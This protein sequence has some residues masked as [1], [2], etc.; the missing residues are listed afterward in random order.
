MS[1]EKCMAFCKEYDCS[2]STDHDCFARIMDAERQRWRCSNV[3]GRRQWFNWL[4][5]QPAFYFWKQHQRRTLVRNSRRTCRRAYAFPGDRFWKESGECLSVFGFHGG[6]LF[7]C[8]F[9]I[10]IFAEYSAAALI[11]DLAPFICCCL[12]QL[13]L[14]HRTDLC[15]EPGRESL[16]ER[17]GISSLCYVWLL[18]SHCTVTRLDNPSILCAS[19]ILGSRCPAR[20]VNRRRYVESNS[21]FMGHDVVFLST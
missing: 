12:H 17:D 15:H 20:N 8:R 5:V 18:V 2:L 14:D 10:W 1:T 7:H 19:P 16:A 6:R 4:M 21:D 9:R 11:Y 13:R 3:C